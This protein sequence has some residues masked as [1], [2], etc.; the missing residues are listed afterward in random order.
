MRVPLAHVVEGL[1]VSS[2]LFE[3]RFEERVVVGVVAD[4]MS[5]LPRDLINREIHDLERA[6]YD[7]P[8]HQDTPNLP[9]ASSG[10][11]AHHP[12]ADLSRKHQLNGHDALS[13]VSS[14]IKPTMTSLD[15]V[16]DEESQGPDGRRS[17]GQVSNGASKIHAFFSPIA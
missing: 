6:G 16:P 3:K 8:S 15:P 1:V 5:A 13:P 2:S 17:I 14:A 9:L 11:G 4:E 10:E 7:L 12:F